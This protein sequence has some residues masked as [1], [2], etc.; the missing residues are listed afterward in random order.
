MNLTS[1]FNWAGIVSMVLLGYILD[2]YLLSFELVY[3]NLIF[4]LSAIIVMQGFAE[5]KIRQGM[6]IIIAETHTWP[7]TPDQSRTQ[8]K[9]GMDVRLSW[10]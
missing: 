1:V 10:N 3:P 8:L 9:T 6:C 5:C 4:A 2:N 7:Y